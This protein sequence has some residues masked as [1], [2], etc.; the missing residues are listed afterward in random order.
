[1]RGHAL[2]DRYA[3]CACAAAAFFNSMAHATNGYL[4]DGYEIIEPQPAGLCVVRIDMGAD[5]GDDTVG[6]GGDHRAGHHLA[7]REG[8]RPRLARHVQCATSGGVRR[9]IIRGLRA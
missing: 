6:S 3:A 5:Q 1:M 9:E 7:H 8:S 2:A 4:L